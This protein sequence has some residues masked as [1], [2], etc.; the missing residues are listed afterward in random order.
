MNPNI[1]HV[2]GAI[3]TCPFI[4]FTKL[5]EAYGADIASITE[6]ISEQAPFAWGDNNRT[7]ITAA[8]LREQILRCVDYL[9]PIESMLTCLEVLDQFYI[10]MEN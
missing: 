3:E 10:D 9:D 2:I 5:C 8:L 4:P 7:L 1:I 6:M